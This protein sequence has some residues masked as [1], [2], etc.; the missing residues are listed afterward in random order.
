[1][2]DITSMSVQTKRDIVVN[3]HA[4][5]FFAQTHTILTDRWELMVITGPGTTVIAPYHDTE[6]GRQMARHIGRHGRDNALNSDHDRHEDSVSAPASHIN[7]LKYT[8]GS[9]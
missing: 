5:A 2:F 1:M 3:I 6:M 8:I 9:Q 4:P 7:Y